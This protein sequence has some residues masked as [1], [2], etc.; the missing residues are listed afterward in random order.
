MKT[1]IHYFRAKAVQVA[2]L[3]RTKLISNEEDTEDE[4]EAASEAVS[5]QNQ[6]LK[7]GAKKLSRKEAVQE[8]FLQVRP[9]DVVQWVLELICSLKLQ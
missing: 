9:T 6:E 2:D 7:N 1:S 8:L 3:L 5:L 4:T